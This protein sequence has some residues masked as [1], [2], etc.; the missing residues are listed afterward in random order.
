M[1]SSSQLTKPFC[2][3]GRKAARV[4][5]KIASGSDLIPRPSGISTVGSLILAVCFSGS[6]FD[7]LRDFF[8]GAPSISEKLPASPG[9][10]KIERWRLAHSQM[11]VRTDSNL[12]KLSINS[13]RPRDQQVGNGPF[14]KR[15]RDD[16]SP[17]LMSFRAPMRR[18]FLQGTIGETSN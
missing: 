1:W 18:I 6:R 9:R 8:T 13:L 2:I 10:R 3:A 12:C 7:F 14:R 11:N 15:S 16:R 4:N 5:E 17:I